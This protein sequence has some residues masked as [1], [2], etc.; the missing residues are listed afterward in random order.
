MDEIAEREKVVKVGIL[1]AIFPIL[2]IEI[3]NRG[4]NGI[5][6]S[7][8]NYDNSTI[9]NSK[10]KHNEISPRTT[11]KK[12][13]SVSQC[14]IIKNCLQHWTFNSVEHLSNVES[15]ALIIGNSY[16]YSQMPKVQRIFHQ[17]P[18]KLCSNPISPKAKASSISV[19]PKK[20]RS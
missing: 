1:N 18:I 12:T 2:P 16:R 20:L 19:V 8:R 14:P 11:K 4:T 17:C 13:V 6:S 10:R 7:Q 3:K 5:W 9:R 15:D